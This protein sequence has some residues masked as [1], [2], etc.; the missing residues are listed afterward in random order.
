MVGMVPKLMQRYAE[1]FVLERLDLSNKSLRMF[2]ERK[3]FGAAGLTT[4][5]ALT[6]LSEPYF[7]V[8]CC[9]I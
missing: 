7:V 4:H 3:L 8:F 6:L 9:V 2:D 1:N 5:Y